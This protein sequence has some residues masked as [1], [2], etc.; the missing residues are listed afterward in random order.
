MKAK[1][2]LVRIYNQRKQ[3]YDKYKNYSHESIYC[4]QK[5]L[6]SLWMH[7][8]NMFNAPASA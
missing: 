1:K 7:Q 4:A 6:C 2:C 8:F 3:V 5:L